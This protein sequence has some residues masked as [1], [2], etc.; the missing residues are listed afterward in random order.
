M[1]LIKDGVFELGIAKKIRTRIYLRIIKI[2]H[3]HGADN[4]MDIHGKNK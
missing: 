3:G 4:L 2:C 1:S